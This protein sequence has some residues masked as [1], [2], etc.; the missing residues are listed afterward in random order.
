MFRFL[1]KISLVVVL[2]VFAVSGFGSYASAAANP[3]NTPPGSS[4]AQ[5]VAQRK[6]ERKIKLDDNT[7]TRLQGQCVYA[8][9]NLRTLTDSYSKSSD[10]RDKVYR[11]IDAKLWIVIG[12]LKLINKDTFSLEQQR[13]EYLKRVQAFENQSTQFQQVINDMLAMNCKADPVGFKALLETARIYN[14]QVRSSFIGIK[15][16][17][18]DQVQQTVNQQADDLKLKTST[19]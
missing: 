11:S 12:S 6:K 5:R 3:A 18:I 16:Y 2:C 7:K 4:L 15:S 1:N 14:A 19:Q 8:Q 9:G 10:S 13:L 17:L